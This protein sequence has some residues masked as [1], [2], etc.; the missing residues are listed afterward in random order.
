M[1]TKTK[2]RYSLERGSK[3]IICPNCGKKTFKCYVD[4]NTGERVNPTKYGRCE[5]INACRYH[6]YPK[7]EAWEKD[8]LNNWTPPAPQP[9]KPLDYVPKD[10]V[11]AT[12][13]QYKTN[14]FYMWLVKLFG[15]DKADSLRTDYNIGTA[16]GG[17]TIF[18]QEDRNGNVRTGKVMYYHPNGKRI[19]ER[20]SWFLHSKIKEDFN[21]RQCFFGLHLTTPDKPVA[22]CES[23]KTAILMSVFMPEYTW[24]A[25]GGSE[26]LNLKRLNELPRLDLVCP[27]NGQF[28]KWEQKTRIFTNRQM[29]LSVDRAVDNGL[30]NEGDDILDLWFAKKNKEK[31]V[32]I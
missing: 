24:V 11:N 25:S 17:G 5:K 30:I 18:W 29:D 31:E 2:F 16:K 28:E 12:F 26:M 7:L 13:N 8:D 20:N 23:E 32:I 22:L 27:D 4:V 6:Q 1:N 3:H 14:I 9:P 21:Y 15:I 10:W 19:K